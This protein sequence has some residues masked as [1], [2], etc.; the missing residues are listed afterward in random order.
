MTNPNK[1]GVIIAALICGWHVLW[2]LFV[3]IGWAQPLLDF[4]FW[5]H[6]INP[7]YVVKA[8]DPKAALTLIIITFT[9]GYTFGFVGAILWNKL[10]RSS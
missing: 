8:F 5:A 4:V 1:V 3:L 6:M 9:M 7:V 2:L 10:H